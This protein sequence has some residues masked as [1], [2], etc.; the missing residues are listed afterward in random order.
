MMEINTSNTEASADFSFESRASGIY[1]APAVN[2]K[3]YSLLPSSLKSQRSRSFFRDNHISS[4]EKAENNSVASKSSKNGHNNTQEFHKN[5]SANKLYSSQVANQK[6]EIPVLSQSYQAS[7]FKNVNIKN[8]SGLSLTQID[9]VSMEI[10]DDKDKTLK[11]LQKSV[12]IL[13]KN[14]ETV[15]QMM[16]NDK[17]ES[18]N[19]FTRIESLERQLE[20]TMNELNIEKKRNE[21]LS[22]ELRKAKAEIIN[23]KENSHENQLKLIIKKLKEEVKR[24]RANKINNLQ[25]V[26]DT[27]TEYYTKS[28]MLKQTIHVLENENKALQDNLNSTFNYREE[29]D[30]IK[31][32]LAK[33]DTEIEDLQLRLSKAITSEKKLREQTNNYVKKISQLEDKQKLVSVELTSSIS[34]DKINEGKIIRLTKNNELLNIKNEELLATVKFYK[35]LLTTSNRQPTLHELTPL[36]RYK[37]EDISKKTEEKMRV[38]LYKIQS[39]ETYVESLT[40]RI[41]TLMG[42]INSLRIEQRKSH[43]VIGQI[44]KLV[45]CEGDFP[46]LLRECVKSVENLVNYVEET[47]SNYKTALAETKALSGQNSK[48]EEERFNMHNALEKTRDALKDTKL[49]LLESESKNRSLIQENSVLKQQISFSSNEITGTNFD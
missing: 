41:T 20:N 46:S 34:S 17:N 48:Y 5:F 32:L 37:V 38:N 16:Q 4:S 36:L 23:A 22:S 43:T 9:P 2:Y 42:I 11:S 8:P 12:K 24:L 13:S 7:S 14:F 49:A 1:K 18:Y 30:Q 47:D 27:K 3:D 40:E 33:K 45:G 25:R 31:E 44:S 39:L 19:N 21:D 29:L 15:S 10:I 6:S 35:E 26:K 28:K